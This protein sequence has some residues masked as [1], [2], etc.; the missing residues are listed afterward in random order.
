MLNENDDQFVLD[1]HLLDGGLGGVNMGFGIPKNAK[2]GGDG[3]P[4]MEYIN[5]PISHQE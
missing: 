5:A 4:Y 2:T 1:E 3:K